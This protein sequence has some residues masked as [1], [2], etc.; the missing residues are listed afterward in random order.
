[1]RYLQGFVVT[2]SL[3]SQR[4]ESGSFTSPVRSILSL[5]ITISKSEGGEWMS[6]R[7]RNI[8]FLLCGKSNALQFH[9]ESAK[10][11]G[12]ERD[13]HTLLLL[14]TPLPQPTDTRESNGVCH[15]DFTSAVNSRS[16]SSDYVLAK[17]ARSPRCLNNRAETKSSFSWFQRVW[18]LLLPIWQNPNPEVPTINILSVHTWKASPAQVGIIVSQPPRSQRGIGPASAIPLFRKDR[19]FPRPK[20]PI[21]HLP[22]PCSPK[23]SIRTTVRGSNSPV[24]HRKWKTSCVISGFSTVIPKAT[25]TCP[26][27]SRFLCLSAM[28]PSTCFYRGAGKSWCC[29]RRLGL[30][31]N[32]RPSFPEEDVLEQRP[33][34]GRQVSLGKRGKDSS[35]QWACTGLMPE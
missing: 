22:S 18:P 31:R 7:W 17:S 12:G 1:M 23:V 5:T 19:I 24:C 3:G 15:Q 21:F 33:E 20:S 13:L 9:P 27:N 6:Q 29:S 2:E 4:W 14:W 11:R 16:P 32:I 10:G 34:E 35:W 30:P 8:R 25:A 26:V 28:P